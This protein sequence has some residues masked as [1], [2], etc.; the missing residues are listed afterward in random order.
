MTGLTRP[1]APPVVDA[2]LLRRVQGAVDDGLGR[3]SGGLQE[4]AEQQAVHGLGEDVP[5][6]GALS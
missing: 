4:E 2:V 1:A 5:E 6:D 3:L